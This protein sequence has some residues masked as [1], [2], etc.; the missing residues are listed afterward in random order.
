MIHFTEDVKK[1]GPL[2]R[3]LAGR[4]AAGARK[5]EGKPF[6]VVAERERS[7]KATKRLAR[8]RGVEVTEERIAGVRVL[9]LSSGGGDRGTV[10]A[11]HGGAY[12]L[13]IPEA[14][15]IPAARNGGPDV[16]SVDY[17]LAP[18]HP[19]P[20]AR[21]D[22]M[23][24]YRALLETVGA[25]KLAVM[26]DS[27]GG[28]LALTLLQAVA[29]EGLPMPAALVAM[30]PWGDLSLSGESCT[31]NR[32]RDILVHSEVAL[33]ADWYADGRDLRD[34]TYM[35]V[36]DLDLIRDDV[37]HTAERMRADGVSVHLDVFPGAP[38]GF[39]IVPFPAA[40][41]CNQRAQAFLGHALPVR[42][43]A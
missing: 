32:G 26:G 40:R 43:T 24:V 33:A 16:V 34:P 38:H 37:K 1:A 10:L 36:G 15:S 8:M 27:A 7:E 39:N 18:E 2:A 23:A 12:V 31:T 42:A 17:R 28:G 13:G 30:F 19:F 29:A 22:A 35:A 4:L 5:R 11:F 6:D 3:L 9:R 14:L 20:A 41:Q 21:D 25:E